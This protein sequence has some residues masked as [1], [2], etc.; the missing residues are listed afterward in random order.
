LFVDDI[1]GITG[2]LRLLCLKYTISAFAQLIDSSLKK[3]IGVLLLGYKK[4][5]ERYLPQDQQLINILVDEL[6]IALQN[7]LRLKR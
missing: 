5:G 7:A 3:P 6:S 4:S 1:E 2:T